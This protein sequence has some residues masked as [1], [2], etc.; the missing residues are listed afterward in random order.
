[1]KTKDELQKNRIGLIRG[2]KK[3]ERYVEFIHSLQYLLND[4]K[5]TITLEDVLLMD[6]IKQSVIVFI[7]KNKYNENNKVFLKNMKYEFY[8]ALTKLSERHSDIDILPIKLFMEDYYFNKKD[9][10]EVRKVY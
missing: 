10:R 9:V 4:L 5:D 6:D 3:R 2:K 7:T 1:M 8:D